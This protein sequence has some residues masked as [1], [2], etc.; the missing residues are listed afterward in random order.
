MNELNNRNE[1]IINENTGLQNHIVELA[2]SLSKSTK[3]AYLNDIKQFFGIN[4]FSELTINMVRNVNVATSNRYFEKMVKLGYAEATIN[5]KMQALSKFYKFMGRREVGVMNYNPFSSDEGS[6]RLKTKR[7]S[8]TRALTDNEVKSI[9][10]IISQDRSILG[11]RNKIM[12]L[13]L[14]TTGMRRQELAK[15]KIDNIGINMGKHVIEY[16]AKGGKP[17]Y[18]VIAKTIKTYIDHYIQ[19]RG[20]TYMDKDQPLLISHSSNADPTKHISTE[21][22]YQTIKKVANKAG[23]EADSISPHCFRHTYITKS[24]D[25]GCTIEDV[26]DRVGHADISTTRRYDHTRRI[27]NN[28]PADEMAQLYDMQL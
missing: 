21:T 11:L 17:M 14:A 5:R 19:L 2:G 24:L 1:I 27:I 26:Q 28:N 15:L 13:L 3:R 22:I 20:L 18:I 4:D 25:M 6:G 8:N 10:S 12:V 23:L 9:M 16:I 7:Y